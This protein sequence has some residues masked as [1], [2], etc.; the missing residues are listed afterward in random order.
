LGELDISVLP[1]HRNVAD[2]FED[3]PLL[4]DDD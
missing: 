4:V 1:Y 3:P 2:A